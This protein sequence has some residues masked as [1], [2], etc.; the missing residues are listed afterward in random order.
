MGRLRATGLRRTDAVALLL[1]VALA[2]ASSCGRQREG[3]SAVP[4][5][6]SST[7]PFGSVEDVKAYLE[8]IDP[9]IQSIARLQQQYEE[10]LASAREGAAD[11]RGTGRNLAGRAELVKP[12]LQEVSEQFDS[13]E[14]PP[15]LAP[16]H[17]DVRK[18]I[19]LRREAYGRTVEGWSAEQR[20][21]NFEAVYR[22]AEARF[23]EAN[24]LIQQLNE[25]MRKI[26]GALEAAQAAPSTPSS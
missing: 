18:L 20:G 3:A 8:A 10:G 12:A 17:R 11:R 13:I 22:E 4:P 9:H 5:G 26:H 1:F 15:L 6:A 23:A 19:A 14:P 2:L 16:F 24:Q 21:D 7:S 25:Q